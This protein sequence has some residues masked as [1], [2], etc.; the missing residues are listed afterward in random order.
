LALFVALGG[1]AAAASRLLIDG[2]S[3]K[4]GSIP[5]NRL[6]AHSVGG[7]Q[8]NLASLGTVPSA[9]HASTA[10]SASSANHASTAE[11]ATNAGNATN[12]TNANHASTADSA[13]NANHASSA[14]SA[15]NAT[16]ASSADSAANA[17]HASTSDTAANATQLGGIP[18]S[19]FTHSDCTSETG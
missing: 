1:T 13:T 10:A 12:A 11:V 4:L 19:G 17:N 9:R 16:H 8:I 2:H 5:G 14:D 6:A 15:T 18:P 7:K 3:I